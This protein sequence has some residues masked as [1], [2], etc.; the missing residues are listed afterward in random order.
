LTSAAIQLATLRIYI[1]E[2]V[3]QSAI[4]TVHTS[5]DPVSRTL[6]YVGYIAGSSF[7]NA[8]IEGEGASTVQFD[9]GSTL[10][11]KRIS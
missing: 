7:I 9:T 1:D 11:V 8:T 10:T 3:E 2:N 6:K 4:T 5:V